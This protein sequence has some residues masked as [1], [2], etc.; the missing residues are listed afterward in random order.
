MKTLA[1]THYC[2]IDRTN[3]PIAYV[4]TSQAV[5]ETVEQV[6][7]RCFPAHAPIEAYTGLGTSNTYIGCLNHTF[8]VKEGTVL[9]PAWDRALIS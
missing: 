3:T 2:Y 5:D 9:T 7:E 6:I 1:I 4:L 8:T